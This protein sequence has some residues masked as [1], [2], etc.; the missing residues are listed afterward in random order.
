MKLSNKTLNIIK[1]FSTINSNFTIT[2][3]NEIKTISVGKNIFVKAEI[4]ETLPNDFGI[5]DLNEFI[6]VVSLFESPDLEFN[7]TFVKISE[8]GNN[9]KFLSA[10]PEH[11]TKIPDIKALPEPELSFTLTNAVLSS[12]RKAASALKVSDFMIVGDEGQLS[13]SVGDKKNPSS[14]SFSSVIG[15]CVGKFH[16][17]FKVENLKI[18]ND[19][20]E[21]SIHAKKIGLFKAK[22][23]K[24]E[25][26][27]ALE[28]DSTFE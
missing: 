14:N 21:V 11:L 2:A 28:M 18:M 8:N 9:V 20:Y 25:Y 27:I 17:N 6:G 3:G 1:N 4:E 19:D 24:L 10:N 7:D 12:I 26:Y 16:L 22:N 15:E 13:V 5:Y 23:Q